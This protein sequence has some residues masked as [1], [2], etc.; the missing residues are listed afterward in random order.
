A[1]FATRLIVWTLGIFG[2]VANGFILLLADKLAP[3]FHVDS[4]ATAIV[5]SLG[6]TAVATATG[7]LLAIDDDV[8]WRRNLIR[9]MV[10]RLEPPEPTEVPGILFL[11]IDGLSESVLRRAVGEGYMPTMARWVRSGTH[12]VV[13]WECDLSSQT[14][15]SQAGILHGNNTDLPAF[16][17][18]DKET[19]KVVTSNRPGDAAEIERRQSDGDGLLS[20]GGVSRSNVF[21]GDSAD[22][23]FTFSTIT[24]R[25][26]G[27]RHGLTYFLSEP[28]AIT[29]LR[30]LGVAEIGREL[31]A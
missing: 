10:N 11:Q 17:W 1:R 3:G 31:A 23:M 14:G 20:G 16:R 2:L 6:M 30:V 13:G 8:V 29:R 26:H 15:A 25:S 27:R 24:D 4:L 7:S 12:H 28:N 18:Y 21:S 19:G 9:R 5:A 22:S